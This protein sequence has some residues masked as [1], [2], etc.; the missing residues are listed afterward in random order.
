MLR[1]LHPEEY[2]FDFLLDNGSISLS[3]WRVLWEKPLFFRNDLFV[4]FH[5]Q[6]LLEEYLHGKIIIP[7][8][9]GTSS[10]QHIAELA[11][12]QHLA[13]GLKDQPSL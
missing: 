12:L 13:Q 11:A 9:G 10:V 6:Q 1:P 4:D 7:R 8:A 2:L 5:Y 3:F